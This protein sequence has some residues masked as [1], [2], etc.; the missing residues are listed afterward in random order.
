MANIVSTL[1]FMPDEEI[2]DFLCD[3][4]DEEL[5]RFYEDSSSCL[6]A[7]K[8]AAVAYQAILDFDKKCDST[9]QRIKMLWSRRARDKAQAER[10]NLMATAKSKVFAD[11]SHTLEKLLEYEVNETGFPTR[12]GTPFYERIGAV[13]WSLGVIR[14][15]LFCVSD[16]VIKESK[17]R[18]DE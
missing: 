14:D 4:S 9:F 1:Y 12:A 2:P 8:E 3:L 7:S 17:K 11:T 10:R 13:S 18:T 16:Y 15:R 6:D 5:I